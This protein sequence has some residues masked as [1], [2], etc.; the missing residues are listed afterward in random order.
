MITDVQITGTQILS[1]NK[2]TL[3][4]ITYSYTR[5]DGS[6]TTQAREVYDRGDGAVILLYNSQQRTVILTRQFR[7]PTYVNGNTTGMLIEACA[8]LLDG[9]TPEA[10]VVRES[11]EETG[12]SIRDVQ[13]VYEIYMSPGA[14]TEKLYFFVA[15]YT[16]AMKQE[17]GGGAEGE[18]E[19]IDVLEVPFDKAMQMLAQGEIQDAKTIILLQYVKIHNLVG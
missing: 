18:E 1:D 9:D 19:N 5:A 10:C 11:M 4:K 2:Y 16:P 13:K 7:L 3:K 8:G 15:A 6:H 14:V 12:Y 17:D